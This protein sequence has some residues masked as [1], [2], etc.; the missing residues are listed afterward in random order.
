MDAAVKYDCPHIDKTYML[1]VRN[2]LYVPS[3]DHNL[4][5]PFVLREAE[6]KVNYT[7]KIHKKHPTVDDHATTFPGEGPR[8]PL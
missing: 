5:P 2:A 1:L 3:M 7:P 8:I 6:I 4:I